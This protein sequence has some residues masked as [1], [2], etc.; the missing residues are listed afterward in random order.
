MVLAQKLYEGEE[1]KDEGRVGL[2]TYMRTDSVSIANEAEIEVRNISPTVSVNKFLPAAP[3][4]YKKKKQAQDAHE[5]IRPTG[6]MRSPDKI[7]DSLAADEFRLYDLIWKR[8]VACQMEAAVLDQTSV[9]IVA[10]SRRAQRANHEPLRGAQG[11]NHFSQEA[12]ITR[13]GMLY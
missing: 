7:K 1:L 5:A 8:F 9:D 10:T 11:L 6:V 3:I 4:K 2:I 12:V 13:W